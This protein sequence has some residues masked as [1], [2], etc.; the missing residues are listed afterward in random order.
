MSV[1]IIPAAR[2]PLGQWRGISLHKNLLGQIS[3]IA[4]LFFINALKSNSLKFKALFILLLI[5]SLALFFGAKSSTSL[6]TLIILF[7][8]SFTILVDKVFEPIGIRRSV[9]ILI[10]L[11]FFVMMILVLTTVPEIFEPFLAWVGK[12]LTFT[13]RIHIWE[14]IWGEAEKHLLLG[15]GFQ[16][17]WVVDTLRFEELTNMW[18]DIITQAHNGYLDIINEVGLIGSILF[19]LVLIN[20]FINLQKVKPAKIWKWFILVAI[21][22]NFSEST[23]IITRSY[24]GVMFIFSYLTIFT[25]K[26]KADSSLFV[27]KTPISYP[28]RL[29]SVDPIVKSR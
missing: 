9:S 12:D 19:L 22:I 28:S 27:E 3:L 15:A 24:T 10:S 25:D 2:D 16:G 14:T 8:I 4:I 6:F 7:C 21:I 17:F 20:G 13:G 29:S 5:I 26:L 1:F 18:H 11:S 23:F